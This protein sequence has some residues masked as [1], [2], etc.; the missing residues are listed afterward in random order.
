VSVETTTLLAETCARLGQRALVGRVAMDHPEGTPDWYRDADA[1]TGIAASRRSIE[2]IGALGGDLVRPVITPRFIP[3]CTDDLLS[4]LARLAEETGVGVQT[5][6]SE[7]DWQHGAAVDRYATSDTEA[8]DRFGLVRPHTILAHGTHLADG[9]LDLIARR[10]A[11]VAHCPLS[12][13]YFAGAVFPARRALDR[14]VRIGLGT[15][16]AGGGRPD[17]W[18]QC[19]DAVTASRIRATGVDARIPAGR[20]GDPGAAIDI[21]TAFWMATA[22]GAELL[23]LPVGVLAV[24][25]AFDAIA[26]DTATPGSPLRWWPEL[27]VEPVRRFEKLVRLVGPEHLRHVWVAGRLVHRAP[28]A[29]D[30]H[31][32]PVPS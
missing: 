9:D 10:G 24:G 19:A 30:G 3:A 1:A 13:A 5:H 15:D 17:L 21:V 12:N 27:D 32:R 29:R 16:V 14:G 18:S 8:L 25:R 31:A 6:C 7:S 22:G 26:V 2:E 28:D 23:G 4:G 11:G 20:R